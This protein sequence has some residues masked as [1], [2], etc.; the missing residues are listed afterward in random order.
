MIKLIEDELKDISETSKEL[1]ANWVTGHGVLL[2]YKEAEM[3]LNI[4]KIYQGANPENK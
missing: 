2:S 4:L 3:I 1:E